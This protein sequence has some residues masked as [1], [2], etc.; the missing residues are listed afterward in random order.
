MKLDRVGLLFGVSAYLLWGLFPLYWPLLEPSGAVEI[1]SHRAIWT[2][3]FCLVILGVLKKLAPTFAL[4]KDR[5]IALR[6]ALSSA[7]VSINWL[8]YIWGVN[9]GHVVESALGYYINPLFIIAFGVLLLK[10]KLRRLQWFSVACAAAGVLILTLD[11]G[12]PPWIAFALALSWG[13]YGFVKKQL[14]LGALEGLT[15]ET[16]ISTPFYLGYLLFLA[17]QGNSHFGHGAGLTALLIGAGIVTGVPLLLFNGC[18]NRLPFTMIG[19]LQYLTPTVNFLIGVFVRHEKMSTPSWIGFFAIWGAL[20]VLGF[21]LVQSGR[22][23]NNRIAK[24]D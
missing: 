3:V 22:S 14:G 7:L 20:I 9:H 16:L 13:G 10:E 24:V 4:L 18:S 21:D 5:R 15:I 23:S 1:V 19:L 17:H 6:L 11:Y 2:L 12:R 8:V